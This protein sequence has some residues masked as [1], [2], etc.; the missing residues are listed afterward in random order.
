MFRANLLCYSLC[1][2]PLVL[3]LGT[4]ERGLAPSSLHPPFRYLY[5]L[6]R[7]PWAFLRLNS[8]S[9]QPFIRGEM[10]QSLHH[11]NGSLVLSPVSPCLSCTEELR[12]VPSNPGV[13]TSAEQRG[14]ITSLSLLA[15]LCLMQPRIP[16]TFFATRACCW[17]M[18]SLLSTR[19][20]RYFSAKL[21]FSQLA[22]SM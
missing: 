20:P 22:P 11:L 10:L 5:T 12:T 16:F 8:L 6:I 4:T 19:T 2:L 13:A 18:F 1:P 3:S 17:L 7:S 14:R 15:I 9:T 21:L